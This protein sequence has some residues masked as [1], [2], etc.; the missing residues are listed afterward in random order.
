MLPIL[1]MKSATMHSEPVVT[2][3]EY[4][5]TRII[6]TCKMKSALSTERTYHARATIFKPDLST[7]PAVM[8]RNVKCGAEPALK[9]SPKQELAVALG[10]A[11]S[12]YSVCF[13]AIVVL[14][15]PYFSTCWASFASCFRRRGHGSLPAERPTGMPCQ[16]PQ[17]AA[18]MHVFPDSVPMED[19]LP[20]YNDFGAPPHYLGH[21][22]DTDESLGHSS[23]HKDLRAPPP[24]YQ[25][26]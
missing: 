14:S 25:G 26:L 12:V 3:H 10:V 18:Q 8:R 16:P 2:V 20:V 24:S 15:Y 6:R 21:E 17:P 4:H 5:D 23:S 7:N 11:I 1:S 9:L 13:L 22:W 19:I